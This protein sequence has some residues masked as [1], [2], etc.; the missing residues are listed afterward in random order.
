MKWEQIIFFN[1]KRFVQ[2]YE[3]LGDIWFSFEL[4]YYQSSV[5]KFFAR[6]MN[7]TS[8]VIP[9]LQIFSAYISDNGF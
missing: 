3:L 4:S 9:D 8:S 2:F 5:M 7:S 1:S 6:V